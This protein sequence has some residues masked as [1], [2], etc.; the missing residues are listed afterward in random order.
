[1]E[2]ELKSLRSLNEQY[3]AARRSNSAME[4]ELKS[5]RALNEKYEALQCTNVCGSAVND[6]AYS[7]VDNMNVKVSKDSAFLC[8]KTVG[9]CVADALRVM[10]CRVV[11]DDHDVVFLKSGNVGGAISSNVLCPVDGSNSLFGGGVDLD[12]RGATEG[13]GGDAGTCVPPLKVKEEVGFPLS[14]ALAASRCEEDDAVVSKINDDCGSLCVS[15]RGGSGDAFEGSSLL[16]SLSDVNDCHL[17]SV[18]AKRVLKLRESIR[19]QEETMKYYV[20]SQEELRK[21]N[22]LVIKRLEDEVKALREE[23]RGNEA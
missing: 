17:C 9:H 6:F 21:C 10:G 5:L 2:D 13:A 19:V 4:D 8:E 14:S 16:S 18:L 20:E 15:Y 12:R 1:M 23:L 3:E 7:T 22:D 11:S